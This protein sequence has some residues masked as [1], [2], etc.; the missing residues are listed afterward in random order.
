MTC[1]DFVS[2]GYNSL[3]EL[4]VK[5]YKRMREVDVSKEERVRSSQNESQN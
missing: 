4:D 3:L 5:S 1:L 2:N